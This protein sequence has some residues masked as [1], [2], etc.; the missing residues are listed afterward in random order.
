MAGS[1]RRG[2][3]GLILLALGPVLTAVYAGVNHAAIRMASK[4]QVAGPQWQGGQGRVG[5]D[6]LTS[7]GVD[8]WRLT[9]WTAAFVGVLAVA[10]VV[11]G[12]LLR[13]RARGRTVLLVLS[14][15]LIVPYA[16]AFLVAMINPMKLLAE[17]YKVPDFVS[18]I[19]SWQ[20]SA[21]F[22][23]LAAGLSQAIGLSL[24]AGEGKRAGQAADAQQAP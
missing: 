15:V 19:P 2:P 17:L 8:A 20:S 4:A 11:I 22:L 21:S 9:W 7:L 12:L 23:L 5:A 16:F 3:I 1:G 14:G 24:A 18:G 6:G 10:F 13:R